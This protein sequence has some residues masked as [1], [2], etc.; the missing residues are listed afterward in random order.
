MSR[1][2]TLWTVASCGVLGGVLA[3]VFAPEYRDIVILGAALVGSE[4]F[5]LRPPGRKALPLSFAVAVVLV[6]ASTPV[7]FALVIGI[8]YLIAVA[9]RPEPTRFFDRILLLAE[10]IAE[11]YAIRAVYRVVVGSADQAETRVIVLAALA[12]AAVA[13]V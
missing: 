2:R 9:I 3:E 8:G 4:L 13:P 1:S 5:E 7:Q 10:R 6:L 12:A 11:G